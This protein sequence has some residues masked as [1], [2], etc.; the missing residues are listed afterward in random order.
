MLPVLKKATEWVSMF[1]KQG[2]GRIEQFY[3]SDKRGK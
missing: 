1:R 2:A 3:W